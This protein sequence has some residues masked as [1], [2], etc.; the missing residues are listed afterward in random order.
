MTLPPATPPPATAPAAPAPAASARH[1][2]SAAATSQTAPQAA[3]TPRRRTWLSVL[4]AAC[5]IAALTGSAWWLVQRAKAT[6]PAAE[7]GGPPG[8]P[9]GPPGGGPR[10]P[11]GGGGGV[12]VGLVTAQQGALPVLVDALGTVT[13]P[14][15][16]TLVPQVG[17]VLAEVLFTEGQMVKKGQLLARID[18]R[19]Y[20]Q[21][22]AEAKGQRARDE[23]QLA[24]ARTT[25]ARYQA[26]WDK[27]SIARQ[28]VE[29][30][31]ALVKQLQGTVEADRASE[32]AAQ[33]N[34][35]YTRIHAPIDGRI[36]LRNVDPGN[37]VTANGSTG[38]ATVTQ[39]NP[40]D[41]VFAVPQDRVPE[42]LAAQKTGPL[43]VTALNRERSQPLAQG[44]FRT[45]DNQID[46]ATGTVK[47]KARF[48]NE[49]D[50]LFPNQFVN[51]RLQLGA[52]N[53]VLVPVTAVRSG[54]QGNY[55][56]VVDAQG[57]AHMRR[58]STGLG[59]DDQLLITQ[60]L[61]GGERV[62]TE[63][64]DRVKEGGKVQTADS[65]KSGAAAGPANAASGAGNDAISRR[66]RG[67]SAPAGGASAPQ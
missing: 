46:T 19:T 4:V 27:D 47:A 34:L 9:G 63:G 42:V 21:A 65:L 38:I 16:A 67:A 12:T 45:L 66:R 64:G 18:P 39:I 37:L 59:T 35:D 7:M 32:R 5:L 49:G 51:V 40:I 54:P 61:Q 22:L 24:V 8:G 41:V 56:Y 2:A 44:V 14:V 28:D 20:D 50:T 48:A 60:G 29:T 15:T 17:G 3:P 53:G 33:I 25:L 11:R 13:P 58:V 62:V 23:A 55:V 52:Q 36:G 43:N 26:L 57:T 6:A 31:A 10:G 30:Q 1:L